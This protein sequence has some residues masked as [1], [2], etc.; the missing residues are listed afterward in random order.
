MTATAV[1]TP[2]A[3]SGGLTATPKIGALAT[4]TSKIPALRA[5]LFVCHPHTT[6]GIDT[7][8]AAT[9]ITGPFSS[10]RFVQN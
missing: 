7:M 3:T 8:I 4:M 1:S 9:G 6:N 5:L 2:R 10:I